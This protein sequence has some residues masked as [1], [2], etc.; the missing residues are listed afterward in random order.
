LS[1]A[2]VATVSRASPQGSTSAPIYAVWIQL[3]AIGLFG[4][5]LAVSKRR[6]R[7][8]RGRI[9]AACL[10]TFL[11]FPSLLAMTGCAGGTGIAPTQRTGTAPG[12]YTV[13]LAGTSGNLQHSIPVTLTVQ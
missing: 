7:K 10:I 13:T 6:T 8:M 9:L 3:Q 11:I 5:M 4:V 1:L 12:T 2:T